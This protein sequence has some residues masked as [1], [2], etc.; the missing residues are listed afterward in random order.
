M[1]YDLNVPLVLSKN[2]GMRSDTTPTRKEQFNNGNKSIATKW[3][4]SNIEQRSLID[5]LGDSSY[6]TIALS[7]QV[8]G[9]V[10]ANQDEAH[11]TIPTIDSSSNNKK[12]KAVSQESNSNISSSSNNSCSN[13]VKILK[14]LNVIIEQES[15]LAHYSNK[16][17]HTT[18]AIL[19]SYDI[20]ALSPC[21]ET[22]LAAICKSPHLHYCDIILLDYTAG[23]GHIQ[24]PFKI[25]STHIA[26]AAQKGFTL[27]LNYAPAILDIA[28]RKAFVQAARQLLHACKGINTKKS[29][30]N[31]ILTS[32]NRVLD[33]RD[34]GSMVL[35]N[36]GD[37]R[38]F[39]KVVLGFSDK[40]AQDVLGI[41]AARVI[42]RGRNRK[43]GKVMGS[44]VVYHAMVGDDND[45]MEGHEDEGGENE[46]GTGADRTAFV[47]LTVAPPKDDQKEIIQSNDTEKEGS[48]YE[49]GFLR[50]S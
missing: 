42:E 37:M 50:L 33:G 35:R 34:Y 23:R 43:L 15:D 14:R 7:H 44:G 31:I 13:K 4:G 11:L 28:K 47:H 32:G 22:V 5:R 25:K 39:G 9:K 2:Q 36:A 20:I 41:N 18:Q 40:L 19:Q 10:K 27:E 21:N 26:Q 48:D 3:R 8:H 1:M 38:N 6:S 12:R 16:T 30:L 17:N 46:A 49:D 24:L 29:G 45:K